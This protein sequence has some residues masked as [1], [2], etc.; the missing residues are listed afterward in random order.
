MI[1]IRG[2]SF[3][4]QNVKGNQTAYQLPSFQTKEHPNFAESSTIEEHE[5]S[6]DQKPVKIYWPTSDSQIKFCNPAANIDQPYPG[7]AGANF[8]FPSLW[9]T[10]NITADPVTWELFA[11]NYDKLELAIQFQYV[12]SNTQPP[13]PNAIQDCYARCFPTFK[14]ENPLLGQQ[15]CTE[16][17]CDRCIVSNSTVPFCLCDTWNSDMITCPA[18]SVNTLDID[19]SSYTIKL[20]ATSN[21]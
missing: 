16:T 8:L 21:M 4:Y 13:F 5:F 20:N 3:I 12:Q 10:W 2:P 7:I 9:S 17:E 15:W 6:C 1:N 14:D 18:H 19:T 11:K